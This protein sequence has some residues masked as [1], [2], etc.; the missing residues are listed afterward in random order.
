MES[1][2]EI[3]SKLF[4][5][6]DQGF[7]SECINPET[8]EIDFELAQKYLEDIQEQRDIKIESVALFIKDLAAD[9]LKIKNE[10]VKLKARREAKERKVEV[11]QN[12]LASSMLAFGEKKF[13]TPRVALSFKKSEAIEID[14]EST[15]PKEYLREKIT[16]APDKT[17]L[18]QAIKSGEIIEGVRIVERQ[19]LQI[20]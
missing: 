10:E 20:K 14:D 8:G 18:K 15:L 3:D 2:Y 7:N 19:N 12:Y 17:A 5:L 9:A 16:Y 6:L 1:L 4:E 11:L 13:E